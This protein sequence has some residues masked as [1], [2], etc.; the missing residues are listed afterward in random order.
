MTVPDAM[1]Q[2]AL[3]PMW[4]S[5][6]DRLSS[7]RAVRRVRVGPLDDAQRSAI[8]DLLGLD[9]LPG[10]EYVIPLSKLHSA[11]AEAGTDLP[12]VLTTVVGPIGD[13]AAERERI[14][15]DRAALWSWLE[16]HPE[17]QRQPALR[18][19][20]RQVRRAGLVQGSVA[21]TRDILSAALAVLNRL[22]AEGQPLPALAGEVTGAPHALDEGTRLGNLVLRALAEIFDASVPATAYDKRMLWER[23]GVAADQLSSVVLAAGLRA[24][25][26]GIACDVAR[27]CADAGHVAALTLAQLRAAVWESAPAQVWIVEN[28]SILAIAVDHLGAACPPLVC[29]SGW[30]NTAVM[31]LL[32]SFADLGSDLRYHGDFDGEGLRIAAYVM[33][34]TQ[35]RPWRMNTSDFLR[36]LRADVSGPAPGRLTEAPWDADLARTIHARGES[37]AEEHVTDHLLGDLAAAAR[38]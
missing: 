34:K 1:Q 27:A 18:S 10:T 21:R 36:G 6:H 14:E 12:S 9:R 30:P 4:Q 2:A 26:Q 35:A 37:L 25:G 29:T 32:R 24:P 15:T 31:M 38:H 22:P 13:R 11:L 17:V 19:W 5:V 20:A 33:E 16:N 7:G 23:A 3:L 28:P 8:A